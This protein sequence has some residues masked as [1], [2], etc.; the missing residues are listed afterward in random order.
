MSTKASNSVISRARAKYGRRI[1]AKDYKSMCELANV[2]EVASYL[3]TRTHFS[4]YLKAVNELLVHRN[5][6]EKEL[7]NGTLK[8][9]YN[10]C[11]FEKFVGAHIF[12]YQQMKCEIDSLISFMRFLY[13]NKPK[14]FILGT[15]FTSNDYTKLNLLELSKINSRENLIKYLEKTKYK[16]VSKFIPID[17]NAP[18]DFALI[19][20]ML[21]KILYSHCIEIADKHLESTSAD[22]IKAIFK[23]WCELLDIMTIYRVKKFYHTSDETILSSILG[24]RFLLKETEFNKMLRAESAEEVLNIFKLSKYKR[25]IKEINIENNF[26]LF[27]K[28]LHYQSI[29]KKIHFSTS[30]AVVML[31]YIYSTEAELYNVTNIIEGVRYSLSP[32]EIYNS[33]IITE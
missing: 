5:N 12:E 21:D 26:T 23:Q 32:D 18:F 11:M 17:E 16:S 10:L 22:E 8:E 19:E 6:L 15:E 20:N 30:P 4:N 28:K 7:N 31:A 9:L 24:Y 29:I 3:K 25:F 2:S 13:I 27:C 14:E 1:T 33:L